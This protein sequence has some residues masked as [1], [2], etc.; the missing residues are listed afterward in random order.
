[1]RGAEIVERRCPWCLLR[2]HLRSKHNSRRINWRHPTTCWWLYSCLM[3]TEIR[4]YQAMSLWWAFLWSLFGSK[5]FLIL[6][7]WLQKPFCWFSQ[8]LALCNSYVATQKSHKYL[9]SKQTTNMDA[10]VWCQWLSRPNVFLEILILSFLMMIIS[11][12]LWSTQY[13][14]W[15]I[16]NESDGQVHP[17]QLF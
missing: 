6:F 1:M 10:P 8:S 4:S 12:L 7:S 15:T 5:Y 11:L 3:I 14:R 17:N 13:L 16:G 9:H 2:T